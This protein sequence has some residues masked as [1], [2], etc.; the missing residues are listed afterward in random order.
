MSEWTRHPLS[1]A[2]P[3]MTPEEWD[4][5]CEDIKTNGLKDA[6]IMYEGQ[7]LD[8]WHRVQVCQTL[9]I[10]PRT[11]EFPPDRD[12]GAYVISKNIHR[13]S[14]TASQRAAAVLAVRDIRPAGNPEFQSFFGEPKKPENP[15]KN[16]GSGNCTTVVQLDDAASEAGVSIST[17]KDANTAKKAGKLDEVRSGQKSASQAAKEAREEKKPKQQ[18]EKKPT[19]VEKLNAKLEEYRARISDLEQSIDDLNDELRIAQAAEM[20]ETEQVSEIRKLQGY[21]RTLESQCR[22]YQ[23]EANQWKR[24]AKALRKRVNG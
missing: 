22:E 2:F 20:E 15:S 1:A 9:G 24:E 7:V 23:N 6:V 5:L 14:L 10:E 8:G 16:A 18:A 12:A 19:K 13:R 11:R 4:G 3:D 21:I 17:M